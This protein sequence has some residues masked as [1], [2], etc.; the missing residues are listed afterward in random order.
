MHVYVPV[1]LGRQGVH[2][3]RL[4]QLL[5]AFGVFAHIVRVDDVGLQ[6]SA[7]GLPQVVQIVFPARAGLVPH[8][9]PVALHIAV[10]FCGIVDVGGQLPVGQSFI[11]LVGPLL[12]VYHF[13][14]LAE[15]GA[16]LPDGLPDAFLD[17]GGGDVAVDQQHVYVGA[18]GVGQLAPFLPHLQVVAGVSAP[19]GPA[20]DGEHIVDDALGIAVGGL[21]AVAMVVL[22]YQAEAVHVYPLLLRP[23]LEVHVAVYVHDGLCLQRGMEETEVVQRLDTLIQDVHHPDVQG[24]TVGGFQRLAHRIEVFQCHFGL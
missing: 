13:R 14:Y 18:H 2:P 9:P 3:E 17:A 12:L 6:Q 20:V 1:A 24:H 11:G 22:P 7:H 5:L 4:P 15:C 16:Q 19:V 23:F 10:Q 8:L 21:E